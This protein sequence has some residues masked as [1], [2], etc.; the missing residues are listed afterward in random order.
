MPLPDGAQMYYDVEPKGN[1]C[2][3]RDILG[4]LT[5]EM[6]LFLDKH[7]KVMR[8]NDAGYFVQANNARTQVENARVSVIDQIK[9]FQPAMQDQ[10]VLEQNPPFQEPLSQNLNDDAI[11]NFINRLQTQGTASEI[12]AP[13][14]CGV[15]L[16][17]KAPPPSEADALQNSKLIQS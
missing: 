15:L 1:S 10:I 4:S 7:K 9:D 12:N 11:P 5:K 17:I 6:A 14:Q 2:H 8:T 3:A 16:A 13:V